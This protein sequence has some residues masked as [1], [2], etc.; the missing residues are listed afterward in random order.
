MNKSPLKLNTT[1]TDTTDNKQTTKYDYQ[2]N[3]MY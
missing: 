2:T 3:K 1:T